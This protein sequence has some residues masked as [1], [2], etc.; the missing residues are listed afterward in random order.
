MKICK[1]ESHSTKS[2]IVTQLS[3]VLFS[4]HTKLVPVFSFALMF[5]DSGF[6]SLRWLFVLFLLI[7]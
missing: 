7:S 1:L 4:L 2:A 5:A 6:V 3:A